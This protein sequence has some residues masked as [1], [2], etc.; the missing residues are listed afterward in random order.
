MNTRTLLTALLTLALLSGTAA[1]AATMP[2]NENFDGQ[3]GTP[4]T[5]GTAWNEGANSTEGVGGT[6][7]T[8]W[9][10]QTDGGGQD[11][12]TI[13]NH[14]GASGYWARTYSLLEVTDVVTEGTFTMSFDWT[15]NDYTDAQNA[16]AGGK[17][18]TGSDASGGYELIYHVDGDDEGKLTISQQTGPSSW[19]S[20]DSA[21]TLPVDTTGATAYTV[22]VNGSFATPGDP[23]SDFTYSA[24]LTDG[25]DTITIAEATD[26]APNIDGDYFGFF[27]QIGH[28][29][30][31]IDE[32]LTTDYDNFSIVV[33][34]PSSLALV[35]LAGAVLA[36]RRSRRA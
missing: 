30:A 15:L 28:T 2:V 5:Q 18:F 23:A 4:S 20:D 10:L 33:P 36:S 34:E 21:G 6:D 31:S 3:T 35:A 25:T 24:S 7:E 16:R 29:G 17:F 14:F 12:R 32:S 26:T 1:F 27:N 19:E 9:A 11:Y 13:T 8:D 22:T